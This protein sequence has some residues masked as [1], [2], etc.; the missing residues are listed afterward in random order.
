VI[1]YI[2]RRILWGILLFIAVTLV[3][4]VIFY[5][6][7]LNPAKL[8][9]GRSATPQEIKLVAHQL[10]LDR[11]LW[12]QYLHFLKELVINHNLG[13]SYANRQSVNSIV[14]AAA[15]IT[16]SLVIGGAILWM[17]IATVIGIVSALRPKTAMDRTTMVGVLA[18]YSVH[19]VWLGLVAI[20]LFAYVPTTG[21]F[22]PISFT[23]VTLFPIGGYCNL[24]GAS[25]GQLCGG[26]WDWFHALML[27]WFVF[28][29]GYAAYYVRM[30]RGT[31]RA[32]MTE[33]YVRTARAKG[34]PESR[35]IRSHVLRNAMLP[36]VTMFGMDLALALG[37]AVIVEYVFGLPGLGYVGV[38][39]LFQFDYPTTLGVVV[40]AT[41]VIIVANL[42]ID[43]LYAWI[44]P[45]IRLS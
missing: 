43:L 22:G 14:L 1:R 2:I 37:G 27:P 40:F 44:D 42:L 15:P 7:P 41:L 39:S 12:Q 6:I 19:P 28:A 3:T 8:A 4:F 31:V 35:V 30:I 13:E 36:V 45:R 18:G 10:Y 33:D 34:A 23:P 24:G 9:A 38:H 26:P 5:V 21:H 29:L 32:T 20:Y 16:A 17:A 11:P 25:A